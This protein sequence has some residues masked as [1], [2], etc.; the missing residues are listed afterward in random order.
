MPRLYFTPLQPYTRPTAL[1]NLPTRPAARPRYTPLPTPPHFIS[2]QLLPLR[3]LSTPFNTSLTAPSP[4]HRHPLNIAAAA[5]SP[6][7]TSNSISLPQPL[8]IP[9]PLFYP[10]SYCTS[11]CSRLPPSRRNSS[12]LMQPQGPQ[13]TIIITITTTAPPP[14]THHSNPP[15]L[16]PTHTDTLTSHYVQGEVGGMCLRGLAAVG[17]RVLPPHVGDV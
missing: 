15:S 11:S 4:L 16:T 6:P 8:N 14:G 1:C 2:S 3:P 9:S 17:S 13:I 5:V 7:L 10:L 12:S